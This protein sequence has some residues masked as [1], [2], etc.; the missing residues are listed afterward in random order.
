MTHVLGRDMTEPLLALAISLRAAPPGPPHP[1]Y[2]LPPDEPPVPRAP[3]RFSFT[4][5]SPSYV[6]ASADSAVEASLAG[7]GQADDAARILF[8]CLG[9]IRAS[10]HRVRDDAEDDALDEEMPPAEGEGGEGNDELE[11]GEVR[12]EVDESMGDAPPAPARVPTTPPHPFPPIPTIS[13]S[14]GRMVILAGG[15]ESSPSSYSRPRPRPR[16]SGRP[17]STPAIETI[18]VDSLSPPPVAV[19]SSS[20]G[21]GSTEVTLSAATLGYSSGTMSIHPPPATQQSS[22]PQSMPPPSFFGAPSYP[23]LAGPPSQPPE[24]IFGARPSEGN[25]HAP[26]PSPLSGLAASFL[27]PNS[28]AG[29]RPAAPFSSNLAGLSSRLQQAPALPVSANPATQADRGEV[30]A[31]S[32]TGIAPV[33]ATGT[34]ARSDVGSSGDTAMD[35]GP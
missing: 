3:G 30:R 25:I 5:D 15:N 28:C 8:S 11:D 18:R 12:E 32:S 1:D 19:A 22:P 9:D 29:N 26:A 2:A 13:D 23:L 16:P 21:A 34:Q 14:S 31:D 20:A 10:L 7:L 4:I 27:S 33:D 17:S 6:P 35:S 24:S